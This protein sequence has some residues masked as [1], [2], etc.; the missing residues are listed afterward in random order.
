MNGVFVTTS[1]L[2]ILGSVMTVLGLFGGPQLAVIALGL[3]AIVSAGAL[4]VAAA[5]RS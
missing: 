4:Q 1:M 3:L 2:V 5:R